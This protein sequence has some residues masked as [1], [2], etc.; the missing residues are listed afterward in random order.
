MFRV[1]NS[2]G[3]RVDTLLSSLCSVFHLS[4]IPHYAL[5]TPSMTTYGPGHLYVIAELAV[6]E[7]GCYCSMFVHWT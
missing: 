3:L 5:K 2:G 4:R 7:K 1:E 6:H